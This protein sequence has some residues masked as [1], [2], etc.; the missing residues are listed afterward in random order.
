M[1]AVPEQ[2]ARFVPTGRPFNILGT[3]GMGRSDTREA[4]RR[5]FEIDAG[6]VVVATLTGLMRDRP[7][8][9]LGRRRRDPPLRHRPRRRRPVPG[10]GVAAS[11]VVLATSQGRFWHRRGGDLGRARDHQGRL[12][13]AWRAISTSPAT[14]IADDLLTPTP[15]RC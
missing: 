3:D 14:P 10:L 12:S 13:S 7:D 8:R 4:L 2:V 11:V 15:P 9:R 1:K 5:Y 6:H